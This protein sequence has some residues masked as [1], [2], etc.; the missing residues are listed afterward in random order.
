MVFNFNILGPGI[1]ISL[2]WNQTHS[3]CGIR[4]LHGAPVRVCAV[5]H[6]G[7]HVYRY[8][9]QAVCFSNNPHSSVFGKQID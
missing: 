7:L 8:K 3:Q 1:P 2:L 6:N 5:T 9:K 4:L